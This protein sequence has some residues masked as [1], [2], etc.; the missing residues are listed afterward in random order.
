VRSQSQPPA[1]TGSPSTLVHNVK[2]PDTTRVP[3]DT[4]NGCRGDSIDENTFTAQSGHEGLPPTPSDDGM[5][6]T[7]SKHV[8]Y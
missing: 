3:S 5:Y 4:G 7:A 8:F 2:S 6:F 1:N